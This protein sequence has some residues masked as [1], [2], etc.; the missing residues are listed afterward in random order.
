MP[1][2]SIGYDTASVPADSA[3]FLRAAEAMERSAKSL[4]TVTERLGKTTRRTGKEQQTAAQKAEQYTRS[5][6][7]VAR[8]MRETGASH[9][10][11]ARA[12]RVFGKDLDRA[13]KEAAQYAR[14]M[15]RAEKEVKQLAAAQRA[16]ARDTKA[17]GSSM[18]FVQRNAAA[19]TRSLVA[20]AAA[21]FGL[22]EAMRLIGGSKDAALQLQA[23]NRGLS[24]SVGGGQAAAAE[25]A[26]LRS[27]VERLGLVLP[28]AAKDLTLLS[29]AA[30]GTELAG[31]PVRELF[32]TLS[33]VAQVLSLSAD[34]L[35]GAFVQLSQGVSKGKFELE[36]LKSVF[37]RIPGSAEAMARGLGVTRA[38][39]FAM[40][41]AG[42]LLT[43]DAIPALVKGLQE[44]FGGQIS[45]G[46]QSDQAAINRLKTAIFEFK[47]ELGTALLPELVK[48]TKELTA[49]LAANREVATHIGQFVGGA[50]Q[51]LVKILAV[52]V[53]N[54]Q[55]L[56]AA[57]VAIKW[58]S[59]VAGVNALTVAL[60][61]NPVIAAGAAIAAGIALVNQALKALAR[62]SAAEIAKMTETSV[63]LRKS[64][65]AI[66]EAI[67]GG[68]KK[69]IENTLQ[70]LTNE[71]VKIRTAV[72]NARAE[73]E[74]LKKVQ[75]E[76]S[77]QVRHYKA[78]VGAGE[79][80][81]R[82]MEAQIVTLTDASLRL[83]KEQ[84]TLADTTHD[85]GE[86]TKS[87]RDEII[88]QIT[89]L[90]TLIS[91]VEQTGERVEDV[92]AALE[93][94]ED[95][96]EGTA[97]QALELVK[98]L[99][100]ANEQA[101]ALAL[102][103]QRL[104]EPL[105]RLPV[106][107]PEFPTPRLEDGLG[108]DEQWAATRAIEAQTA[109][110][111]A[112][113]EIIE[114]FGFASRQTA[115][116]LEILRRQMELGV[117]NAS[118]LGQRIRAA[119]E[120]EF[121][122]IDRIKAQ[123]DA[124]AAAGFVT[125]I[126]GGALRDLATEGEINFD[127]IWDAFAQL[128]FQAIEA[129]IQ[130]WLAA[131]FAPKALS[132]AGGGGGGGGGA[133]SAVSGVTGTGGLTGVGGAGAGGTGSSL[134]GGS[135][136]AAGALTV[137][138]I[139]AA[140][141]AGFDA[142]EKSRRAKKFNTETI[143]DFGRG[144]GQ[145]QTFAFESGI[146]DALKGAVDQFRQAIG[147]I[148]IDLPKIAVRIR[149]DGEK[150][151]LEV[152]GVAAGIFNSAEEALEA[153]LQLA[154]QDAEFASSI[155]PAM[156][157]AMSKIR[158]VGTETFLA[159]IPILNNIDAA[160]EG[161]SSAVA[162]ATLE[163]RQWQTGLD[164]TS[165]SLRALG[166]SL[167]QVNAWR[168]REIQ[169]MLDLQEATGKSL[170]GVQSNIGALGDW[171]ASIEA[172][173]IALEEEAERRRVMA[174]STITPTG[175]PGGEAQG[176][177]THPTPFDE[178]PDAL[179][180]TGGALAQVV[181]AANDA[182]NAL[183]QTT[184]SVAR[185]GGETADLDDTVTTAADAIPHLNERLIEMITATVRLSERGAALQGLLDFQEQYGVELAGNESLRNE[186]ARIEFETSRMRLQMLLLEH[187]QNAEL[188]GLTRAQITIYQ[189]WAQELGALE[190]ADVRPRRRTRGG[191][192]ASVTDAQREAERAAEDL[193]R[194]TEAWSD[195]MAEL[196]RRTSG[197]SDAVRAY[198][199][200]QARL[201]EQFEAGQAPLEEF[202][203]ALALMA[204]IHL[205]AIAAE[206]RDAA[207]TLRQTD[208]QAAVLEARQR[209]QEALEAALVA[210]LD[211]PDAYQA[212]R[213]AIESGLA[214][215][216]GQIG[217]EGLGGFG[218]SLIALQRQGRE[219]ARRIQFLINNLDALGLTADQVAR[220]VRG[221]IM[222][223]LVAMAIATAEA[224]GDEAAAA[225]YRALQHRLESQMQRAQL[226]VWMSMLEAANALDAATKAIFEDLFGMLDDLGRQRQQ[227]RREEDDEE[228]PPGE[229]PRGPRPPAAPDARLGRSGDDQGRRPP[230]FGGDTDSGLTLAELIE[231][232]RRDAMTPQERLR[233]DWL[234]MVDEIA[235]ATGTAEERAIAL[236]MAEEEYNRRRLAGLR[237]L[238]EELLGEQVTAQGGRR[239]FFSA[240]AAFEAAVESGDPEAIE[241]AARRFLDA[242]QGFGEADSRQAAIALA[243]ARVLE[244]LGSVLGGG[245]GT[246]T[247]PPDPSATTPPPPAPPPQTIIV[248]Q[249]PAVFAGLERR[250]D[251]LTAEVAALRRPVDETSAAA[252]A[253]ATG[254]LPLRDVAD[255][256]RRQP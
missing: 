196:E 28:S 9:T 126:V 197:T 155:G 253:T 248:Q 131:Q 105:A 27:E 37:E 227:Q 33:G 29:A 69:K 139:A 48:T 152:G 201:R 148:L 17:A 158:T 3:V 210:A 150:V 221:S 25:Y 77:D 118:E 73:M 145:G 223:D 86:E 66:E 231:Q 142:Y 209:A 200:E 115:V 235:N 172:S 36:D 8:I 63:D 161:T 204:E 154:F 179:G 49:W 89:A 184:R 99:R 61:A 156:Q 72:D 10:A 237:S 102:I 129:V 219:A 80:A 38:E 244:A 147:G 109:A 6:K 207:A 70:H 254:V 60:R 165:E 90:R 132:F 106:N 78:E 191:G 51:A 228:E 157:Q 92:E 167:E 225:R 84:K 153:A 85:V 101:N 94:M 127:R 242:A 124:Q 220:A 14:Q 32:S 2:L 168:T 44:A 250:L 203:H 178:A 245:F 88:K 76:N 143:F 59:I 176:G 43:K 57:I 229:P 249:A 34:D 186:I 39:M 183:G 162:S 151:K 138:A 103:Q 7:L 199:D 241:A 16:A 95:G 47:A 193:A 75:G 53:E 177:G 121:A 62:E 1:D 42:N 159:L 116:E 18:S 190:F 56:S 252:R 164:I 122:L 146:F 194:A 140:V 206:W 55:A 93:L 256:I 125:D 195:T 83:S 141:Y 24:A 136:A 144:G 208:I 15:G 128:G 26:F 149:N 212:A 247:P 71:Y 202:K 180:G 185:L 22:H 255:W 243:R 74:R 87:V 230:G 134:F 91:T 123:E 215:E 82:Q 130:K 40:Q 174:E 188:L 35:S 182:T 192:G 216:L 54:W 240:Q 64:W 171:L 104:R 187:V 189:R 198:A 170:A 45:A 41:T 166:I 251:E 58:P 21:G 239:G 119:T 79:L 68:D 236:A 246:T 5:Q 135:S 205:D 218:N 107:A 226:T 117:T 163:I 67:A 222:P 181:D 12:V 234:D 108:T 160:A 19:L 213:E 112:E 137:V 50:L 232:M 97:A 169:A 100:A 114:R 52:A 31:Q 120:E 173:R 98:Q 81:L 20:T 238:Q 110:L 224:V 111:A 175:A 4:E 11:A 23:I 133:A 46:A 214:A 65:E 96:F 113:V 217:R 13:E 30:K 211:N 233:Q